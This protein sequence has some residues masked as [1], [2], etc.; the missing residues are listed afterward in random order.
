MGRLRL[1][2]PDHGSIRWH[3]DAGG[4]VPGGWL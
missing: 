4:A 3:D 1:T 2:E